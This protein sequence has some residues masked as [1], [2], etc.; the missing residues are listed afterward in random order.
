MTAASLLVHDAAEVVV[1]PPQGDT[2]GA[3]GVRDQFGPD[4]PL[5]V[6]EDAAVA[7]VDETVAAVGPTEQ[8]T[9]E[10]PPEAAATT[11]D[12]SGQAVLPGFVDSH[13]HAA[14]AGDRSDEFAAR[15]GGADY[16]EILAEGGGILRTVR[17]VRSASDE[18]L[19]EGVLDRLDTALAYGATTVEIKSGY[20]LDRE[21]ELR[22]LDAI[23]RAGDRHPVDV[24]PTFMGAHAVPE[25]TT[26]DAYVERVIEDQLPA[27]ADQGIAVFCDVFC[28]EGVFDVEQSRRVLEAGRDHGLATKLHADEFTRLGGSELAAELGVVSADHLL[29][30]TPEDIAALGNAGVVPTY[31]PAAAFSLREPYADPEPAR[32]AGLPVAL[33][34]DFNPNCHSRSLP[35]TA[36][37]GCCGMGLSPAESVVGITRAGALA[38]DRQDGLGTLR[39]GAPGD[40]VLLDAPSYVDLAYRFG[41]QPIDRVC[42]GGTAVAS[43]SEG[44]DR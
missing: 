36:A 33:A 9:A 10:Y 16:Q 5:V 44:V 32:E 14:F 12:A 8:V 15:L 3:Y 31:L 17:A 38:L 29:H 21:T 11:I 41:E 24:V 26:A 7:V 28:E 13:T 30:A 35:M 25:D 23:D 19:V 18:E 34:T 39:Q 27:V 6:H 4:E 42:K 22:L 40:L 2:T 20:G 1:G 43:P 37:L